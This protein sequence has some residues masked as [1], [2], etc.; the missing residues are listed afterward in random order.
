[1]D[2]VHPLAERSRWRVQDDL[3]DGKAFLPIGNGLDGHY[4]VG[5]PIDSRLRDVREQEC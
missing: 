4:E 5:D 3:G 1:M 2:A